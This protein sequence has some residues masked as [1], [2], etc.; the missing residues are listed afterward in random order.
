MHSDQST[1]GIVNELGERVYKRS[2][3][4]DLRA[5]KKVL[6]PFRTERKGI[7]VESTYNW[8]WLVDGLVAAGYQMRA[9]NTTASKQYSGLK[10]GD[11]VSEAFWPAICAA[12]RPSGIFR[13]IAGVSTVHG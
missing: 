5:T 12:F 13:P 10:H 9:G 3:P 7:V 4:N 2:L 6:E 11:D 1:I 8:H